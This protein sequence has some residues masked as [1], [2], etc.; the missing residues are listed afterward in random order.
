MKARSGHHAIRRAEWLL[1]SLRARVAPDSAAQQQP[2]ELAADDLPVQFA[3]LQ[4]GRWPRCSGV[5]AEEP[6]TVEVDQVLG[7]VGGPCLRLP[8]QVG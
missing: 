4:R 8:G 7:S 3:A 5:G 6:L 1:G 2:I